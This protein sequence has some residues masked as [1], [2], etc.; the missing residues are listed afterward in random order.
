MTAGPQIDFYV[1]Q[2]QSLGG[3]FKLACR[4]VEKAYRLGHSVY[5]RTSN[6]DDTNILNFFLSILQYYIRLDFVLSS[7]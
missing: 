6:S 5:V 1:L 7:L 4:I 3:R 2:K